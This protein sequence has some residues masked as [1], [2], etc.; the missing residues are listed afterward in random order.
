MHRFSHQQFDMH[1]QRFKSQ[2]SALGDHDFSCCT[3]EQQIALCVMGGTFL[4]AMLAWRSW[5]F[6]PIKLTVVFQHELCH[7]LATWLT[8]GQVKGISISD[9]FGGVTK[10][11]GGFRAISLSAG[12]IG[13]TMFGCMYILLATS[14]NSSFGGFLVYLASCTGAILILRVE[15][16][17][18]AKLGR[19]FVL[20]I[21]IIIVMAL[22]VLL[23]LLNYYDH[24]K[25]YYLLSF[26]LIAIGT[27]NILFAL[28]ECVEDTFIS[29]INDA[30]RGKSDAVMFAEEFGGSAR[31]WGFIWSLIS[32]GSIAGAI[33]GF[34]LLTSGK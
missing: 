26:G 29:K 10:T 22:F 23:F 20:R 2:Q 18:S 33:Y 27:L 9:N 7:A 24:V 19:G 32:L 6:A 28:I 13:S 17:F 3:D 15:G 34:L 5:I 4:F 8:C 12:Y 21:G 16:S 14:K 30:D 1:M 11:R 25:K 31:C